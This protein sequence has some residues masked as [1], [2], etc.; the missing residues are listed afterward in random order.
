MFEIGSIKVYAAAAAAASRHL[1]EEHAH[2]RLDVHDGVVG[3][4]AQVEPAVVEP[5]L[6]PDARERSLLRLRRLDLL[7]GAC[8]VLAS[9]R[10]R[11]RGPTVGRARR[12]CASSVSR[13]SVVS[14]SSVSR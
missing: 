9:A 12:R 11:C 4:D 13:Q 5:E 2:A 14:Q 8:R 10:A 3:R 1:T 7:L 6:L